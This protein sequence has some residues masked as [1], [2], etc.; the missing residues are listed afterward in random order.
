MVLYVVINDEK[1]S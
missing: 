1:T